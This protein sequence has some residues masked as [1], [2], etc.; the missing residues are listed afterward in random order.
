MRGLCVCVCVCVYFVFCY[1]Q[2]YGRSDQKGFE[3]LLKV[4]YLEVCIVWR[5]SEGY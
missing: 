2:V 3:F 4:L 5:V 1:K